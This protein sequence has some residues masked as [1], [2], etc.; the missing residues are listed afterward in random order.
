MSGVKRMVR[1]DAL[2][3]RELGQLCEERITPNASG[4][5]TITKVHCA[6]D[7]REAM[8]FVSVLGS[9]EQRA[10]ALRLMHAARKDLQHELSRRI[11]LKYTPRLSFRED[12]TAE[13]ADRVMSIL[14][15]LH[16][17]SDPDTPVPPNVEDE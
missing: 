14:G 12:R 5:V 17:P 15:E 6:P 1:V 13:Q 8:V 7:L 10:E 3:L 16:L 9:E 2:L 4:L 11:I